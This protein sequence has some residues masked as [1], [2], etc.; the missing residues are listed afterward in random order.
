M[1]KNVLTVFGKILLSAASFYAGIMI[2]GAVAGGIGLPAPELPAGV[3]EMIIGQYML[4]V[5]LIMAGCLA[6]MARYL[7]GTFLSRWL[8]LAWLV[9]IT[10]AVNN[11]IEGAIFTSMSTAS[12][13]TI[14]MYAVASLLI[15]AVV[16]WLF[17]PVSTGQGFFDNTRDFFAR[18]KT[19]SW[20]WRLVA[21]VIAFPLVYLAFGT[22]IA[23]LVMDY[24]AQ[25]QFQLS[26][27]GWNQIIPVQ[28]LRSILFLI[29][30]L[31][32]LIAWQG[33]MRRL[34]LTL[35]LT[36]FLL[37]GGLSMLQAYWLPPVLRVVHSLEILADELVYS[38]ILVI[39]LASPNSVRE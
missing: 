24:Y 8:T 20:S 22:L 21:A 14:L 25:G 5:S 11:A 19:G 38:G 3:D 2:G 31:P 30:C 39:L 17:P 33:S 12:L 15:G 13:F 36:L 34:F 27:P 37:V 29:A 23:P 10:H 35:G 9:W 4:L 7:S 18:Y 32:V 16:S 1:F 6:I 28:F 26:L